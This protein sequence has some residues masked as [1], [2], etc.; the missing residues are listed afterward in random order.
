MLPHK[1]LSSPLSYSD[2]AICEIIAPSSRGSIVTFYS[3]ASPY[4]C[5]HLA[6]IPYNSLTLP[7]RVWYSRERRN[8]HKKK[9]EISRKSKSENLNC[10]I[11]NLNS[12]SVITSTSARFIQL[13]RLQ[14][15]HDRA[16]GILSNKLPMFRESVRTEST[17]VSD[18]L[19]FI[20]PKKDRKFLWNV[21]NFHCLH[22]D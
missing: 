5:C 4:H 15:L 19:G 21:A 22:K 12:I 9:K 7:L 16:A 17:G 11:Q 6:Y 1:F 20:N 18:R 8:T 13:Y 2:I 10:L 14:A 3:K